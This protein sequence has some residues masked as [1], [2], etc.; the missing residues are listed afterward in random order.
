[1]ENNVNSKKKK[2]KIRFKAIIVIVLI[3]YLIG[4][5]LYYIINKPLKRIEITG[6][7]YLKDNYLINYLDISDESIFKVSKSQIKNKLYELDLVS[8]VKVKKNYLGIL[9][10]TIEEGRFLFYNSN[11]NTLALSNAKEIDYNNFSDY[12]LGVP[13]LTNYVP[14]NIYEELIKKMAR[15]DKS[16]LANISEI[17]YDPSKVGDKIIDDKRFKL[18]MNDGNIVYI[19]TVNIE[20]INDYLDIYEGIVSVNGNTKGCLYLD[21]SSEN[22]HFSNCESEVKDNG[23]SEL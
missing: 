20:K 21:S 5:S 6:N 11:T 8:D 17:A 15:V 22:N 3:I 14:T 18:L 4:S 16:I 19:N 13:T 10:I 12:V 1:M 23:E 7:N 9:K 2:K